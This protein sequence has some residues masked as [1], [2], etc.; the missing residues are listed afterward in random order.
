MRTLKATLFVVVANVL[1]VEPG[2]S[3]VFHASPTASVGE[4]AEG[5]G[6]AFYGTYGLD[7]ASDHSYSV[8]RKLAGVDRVDT[9][10]DIHTLTPIEGN[11]SAAIWEGVDHGGSGTESG[12]HDPGMYIGNSPSPQS[13][14]D[15]LIYF[16]PTKNGTSIDDADGGVGGD[17]LPNGTI[18]PDSSD[19]VNWE[20]SVGFLE[21][22]DGFID[23]RAPNSGDW[24]LWSGSWGSDGVSMRMFFSATDSEEIENS[25]WFSFNETAGGEFPGARAQSGDPDTLINGETGRDTYQTIRRRVG[26][27]QEF[28]EFDG[29]FEAGGG[30]G[31]ATHIGVD[32]DDMMELSWTMELNDPNNADPVK[33]REVRFSTKTGNLEYAAVFDPEGIPNEFG[34]PDTP[35]TD[36]VFDWQNATPVFYLGLDN[37][38]DYGEEGATGIMGVFMP[39]DVNADGVV[40]AADRAIIEENQGKTDTTYSRGDLDQDGDT[41]A[42][43]LAAFQGLNDPAAQIDAIKDL[44]ERIAYVHDVIG[45]WM[46]DSNLDGEFNSGD[47]VSVFATGE[48]EDATDGNST[49]ADGDWNGDMDFNSSDLVVAFADGGYEQGAFVG[50]MVP[51]PASTMLLLLGSLVIGLGRRRR[52]V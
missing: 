11:N 7:P 42:D 50:G 24:D 21:D 19:R 16:G 2:M 27:G 45:T 30:D 5:T 31:L 47:L 25:E 52:S 29:D 38:T 33:A 6:Q 14:P 51:E 41:D 12:F 20:V 13:Y 23:G 15:Q 34:D 43:D 18:E 40:D 26:S 28:D 44:N 49:W 46:G 39:G 1:W 10:F 35:W 36:D 3:Q 4:V 17:N 48:Y 22:P 9:G 37:G 8:Y 32:Y